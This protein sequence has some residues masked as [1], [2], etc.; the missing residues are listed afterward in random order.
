MSIDKM[1][2]IQFQ[3]KFTA[4]QFS[5]NSVKC[6]KE[7]KQEM[8]KCKRAMEKNNMEGARIYA[9]N[10][11]RKKNEALNHL[12]L[13]ARMDAVV[14]RLDTA[15]KM[16]MVTKNMG[17]MVKGMDKILVS[18]DPEKISK[19]MDQFERQF[20]TMDVTSAY[21]EGA[22]GQS[23]ANSMPEDDVN[24]LMSQVADEH[25]LDIREHFNDNLRLT[26]QVPTGLQAEQP[27][28]EAPAAVLEGDDDLEAK[29]ARL[30]GR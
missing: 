4:K 2:D 30:R 25:G 29:F 21:M 3:L 5:K 1:M 12:R 22:I 17:D 23:T 14:S 13:S 9:Q 11:I 16:K 26:S 28:G 8:N 15:I 19:V 6:E 20:E 24:Q 18:M 7:E 10:A 27:Q